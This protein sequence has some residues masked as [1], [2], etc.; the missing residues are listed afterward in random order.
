MAFSTAKHH[1]V[2]VALHCNVYVLN[3]DIFIIKLLVTVYKNNIMSLL[4]YYGL[5]KYVIKFYI[6]I[7]YIY[8]F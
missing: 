5:N 1:T 8:I 3:T 4:H 7:I 2:T 6:C